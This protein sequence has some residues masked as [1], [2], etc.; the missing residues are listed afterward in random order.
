MMVQFAQARPKNAN[1]E[2]YTSMGRSPMK[3]RERKIKG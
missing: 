2:P 3:T 1:G